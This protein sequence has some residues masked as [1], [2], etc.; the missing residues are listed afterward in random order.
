MTRPESSIYPSM[1]VLVAGG[2]GYIGSVTTASLIAGGH[3]VIVLD[4][5]SHGFL[6][7]VHPEAQLVVGDISNAR[8]VREACRAGIDVAM[9]FAAF[10]E[11]GES[12]SDPAKYY[13][14]N[15]Y[16]SIRFLDIL[17]KCGVT[18]LVFSSTAAVYGE[19]E[20]VPLTEDAPLCPV[21]PY[22]RTKRMIEQ[23]LADYDR[24]YS[25]R[26]VSLRYF[27]AG[28]ALG[29]FGEDHRPESH[30]LPCILDAAIRGDAV[31]V[32]GDDYPTRDGSC[33]RDYIHV[34]DLADA[35]ILAARYLSEG[36][37]TDA[38]NLGAGRG[39]T[40]LEVIRAA[41]RIIGRSIRRAAA[42]RRPG[43]SPSLVASAEKAHRALG[44]GDGLSDL[45]EI[46]ESAYAWRLSHPGG[47]GEH[48]D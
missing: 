43:D 16:K 39:Y 48:H 46:I 38:F 5:L 31:S 1:N 24:A 14:N 13:S 4:N 32:Y 20:R 3:R 34:R 25:F 21:N 18:R 10:I 11:V 35:H 15:V 28:G 29:D 30:L 9:H 12:V 2:A 6:D 22:G 17:M 37:K 7:A 27:N 36:G 19:P 44:W 41:E 33:I 8:A 42:A 26:S 47:Y 45:D 40:V 23:V